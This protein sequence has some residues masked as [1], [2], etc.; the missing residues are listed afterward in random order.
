MIFCFEEEFIFKNS[1]GFFFAFFS[2]TSV[3]LSKLK[4]RNN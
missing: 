1:L 2:L 4:A 3:C